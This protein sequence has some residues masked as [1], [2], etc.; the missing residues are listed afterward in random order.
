MAKREP[1]IVGY[2]IEKVIDS[3]HARVDIFQTLLRLALASQGKPEVKPR[4]IVVLVPRK[5]FFQ[6]RPRPRIVAVQVLSSAEKAQSSLLQFGAVDVIGIGLRRSLKIAEGGLV[7]ALE[8]S[9][10]SL[11]DIARALERRAGRERNSDEEP[12]R[13]IYQSHS[14][15][16]FQLR[17]IS[18][19]PPNWQTRI[20]L[21]LHP[22]KTCQ[23]RL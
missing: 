11:S 21:L 8:Q 3:F 6:R 14:Y 10:S 23:S 15:L 9:L 19:P 16:P 13:K 18:L 12:G 1:E 20:C 17:W 4:D 2:V 22:Q 7:V 5:R